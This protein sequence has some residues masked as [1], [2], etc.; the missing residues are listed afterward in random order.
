MRC[1]VFGANES[2]VVQYRVNVDFDTVDIHRIVGVHF[3]TYKDNFP[4]HPP[5]AVYLKIQSTGSTGMEFS[6]PKDNHWASGHLTSVHRIKKFCRWGCKIQYIPPLYCGQVRAVYT[7]YY[8]VWMRGGVQRKGD[9]RGS[10]QFL[11]RLNSQRC[12]QHCN[13]ENTLHQ[14]RCTSTRTLLPGPCPSEE[15]KRHRD[16]DRIPVTDPQLAS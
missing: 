6:C 16:P 13:T 2:S 5:L 14:T 7:V 8:T 3:L 15:R 11:R 4:P 1:N 10:A 12:K 9:R